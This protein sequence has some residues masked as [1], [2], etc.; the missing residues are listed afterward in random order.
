MDAPTGTGR[1]GVWTVVVAAGGGTRFGAPK[2]YASLAGRRVIDWSLDAARTCSEGIVLVVASDQ[3]KRPE[4]GADEVRPGGRTRSESV[5]AGL[6]AIPLGAAVVVVHDGARP[7]AG[8]QLFAAVVAAVRN[9][10]DAAVPGVELVDSVRRRDGGA[11]DRAELVAVQT[12][13]AFRADALR[14][15]HAQGD[16]ATDDATLVERAGGRVVVVA[17]DP[18]N[19]KLTHP[20]DLERLARHLQ[21]V[22]GRP[23]EADAPA[24][25]R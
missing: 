1:D 11:I 2:Q 22:A 5:R 18:D 20:A 21:T 10:A 17:G 16:D 4:P 19:V 3:V 12:P 14:A 23:V 25:G 13:Q 7:A 24:R 15:A 6:D 9:G 8:P